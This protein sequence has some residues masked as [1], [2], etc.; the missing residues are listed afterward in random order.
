MS[1]G[2]I[3]FSN[4][5]ITFPSVG[6]DF[7]VFN[8]NIPNKINSKKKISKLKN[9]EVATCYSK[10]FNIEFRSNLTYFENNLLR[11]NFKKL[12]ECN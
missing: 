1:Y 11:T 5:Q 9:L 8:Q 3:S 10:Y 7:K 6:V 4:F 12:F 2:F